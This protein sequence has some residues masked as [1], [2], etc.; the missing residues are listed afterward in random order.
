MDG[1]DV[2]ILVATAP[3][4]EPELGHV[5]LELRRFVGAALEE[6]GGLALHRVLELV[7][8]EAGARLGLVDDHVPHLH[9]LALGHVEDEIHRARPGHFS[10][11]ENDGVRVALFGIG[12]AELPRVE[13]GRS[14]IE[15]LALRARDLLLE[16]LLLDLVDPLELDRVDAARARPR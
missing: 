1:V 3:H 5:G 4:V 15:E 9:L 6:R 8:V 16:G 12:I 2:R 10:P 7:R 14:G 11:G 13:L